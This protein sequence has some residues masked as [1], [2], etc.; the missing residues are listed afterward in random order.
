MDAESYEQISF[1]RAE[2]EQELEFLLPSSS[3]MLL[4]LDGQAGRDRAARVGRA[5][6]ARHRAGS[7]GRHGVERDEAGDARDRRSRSGTAVRER[8]RPDQGRHARAALHLARLIVTELW[9]TTIRLLSQEP[10]AR[11]VGSATLL[12]LAGTL[13]RAGFGCLEVS[14]GGCFDWLV[15]GGVESPW[16]RIRALDARCSTP[17]GDGPARSLPRRLAAARAR[18]RQTL[19]R[20]RGRERHRRLPDPRS[21]STTS[22][23]SSTR[24]RRCTRPGRKPRSASSTTRAR[25]ASSTSSSSG[26]SASPSSDRRGSSSTTRPGHSTPRTRASSSSGWVRRAGC[27]SACSARAPQGGRSPPRSRRHA[28]ARPRSG[29]RSIP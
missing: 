24:S 2:V 8:R 26:R 21:R 4:T 18:P 14:G 25:P 23:T 1:P 3:L 11:R 7:Q 12:E 15:E 10:L 6:G 22:R 29:A 28:A 27:L 20:E 19:R 16:A 9:D 5:R 17:L 13:D